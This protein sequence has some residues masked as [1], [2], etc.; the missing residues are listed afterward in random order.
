MERALEMFA[1]LSDKTRLRAYR[2]LIRAGSDVAVCE[3]IDALRE[4]QYNVSKHLQ[5]LKNAGLVKEAK[6]GRWSLYSA[7]EGADSG[8][9]QAVLKMREEVFEEDYGFLKKRLALR[10]NGEIVSCKLAGE[11]MES[12][13]GEKK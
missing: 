3:L 4:S 5:V 9:A 2:L 10:R 6:K 13:K 11:L 12:L 7:V 8:I 1:A